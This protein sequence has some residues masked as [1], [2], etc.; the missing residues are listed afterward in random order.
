MTLPAI[1]HP[2]MSEPVTAG[3][4]R[5]ARLLRALGPSAAP[6]WGELSREEAERLHHLME[7]EDHSAAHGRQDD[8]LAAMIEEVK[9]AP[10]QAC[11]AQR[12]V[13]PELS[14]LDPA[15]IARAFESEC[16]QVIAVI[17]SRLS[18]ETAARTVR[19]LPRQTATEALRRLLHLGSV[20]PEALAIIEKAAAQLLASAPAG[21]AGDGHERVARIFDQLDRSAEQGLLASLD[22]SE[23]GAGARVRAL[24][25]TFDDLARLGPAAIQT[26]L[27]GIDRDVLTIALKGASASVR[28]A[29]LS[30]MTKRAGDLLLSEIESA[31]PVRKS[32]VEAARQQM[33]GLARS[34]ARRGDILAAT[35]DGDELVE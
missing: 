24:M 4:H 30:N 34:L 8:D 13:W 16:V 18:P 29:I 22:E 28:D 6:V 25:F 5:A 20:K 35:H 12:S 17:L 1:A 26:I 32:Q 27:S 15:T 7:R 19:A 10:G 33:T 14:R 11:N 31:G 23:P 9:R 2:S 3:T 21:Q